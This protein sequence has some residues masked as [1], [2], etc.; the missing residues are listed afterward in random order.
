M[1]SAATLAWFARHELRIAWRD[2]SGAA[3][4]AETTADLSDL[5]EA[6]LHRA[7]AFLQRQQCDEFGAPTHPDGAPMGLVVLALGKLGARELNFSSDIDLI[8]F[9]TSDR[10]QTAEQFFSSLLGIVHR[11][12]L[13]RVDTMTTEA[14]AGA[15]YLY[16]IIAGE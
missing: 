7:L 16:R 13:Y 3:D 8:Y 14:F 5:A 12:R 4:L 9:Y 10:G 11:E 6:C 15:P 2:L 1:N